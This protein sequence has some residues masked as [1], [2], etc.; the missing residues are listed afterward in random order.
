MATDRESRVAWFA[1]LLVA[2]A[3]MCGP[4]G[5]TSPAM[6]AAA[7]NGAALMARVRAP[8][9]AYATDARVR[10]LSIG[11]SQPRTVLDLRIR[12]KPFGSTLKALIEVTNPPSRAGRLLLVSTVAGVEAHARF[13]GPQPTSSHGDSTSVGEW[14]SPCLA[15]EDL[16]DAHYAW[17]SHAVLREEQFQGRLAAIVQSEPGPGTTSRYRSVRTW[18]DV[19]RLVP[20]RAEK[21]VRAD[22][23][24]TRF[25]YGAIRR[26][27]DLWVPRE[28]DVVS[29]TSACHVQL[30]VLQGTTRARL[31]DALF[32]ETDFGGVRR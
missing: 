24:V 8:V 17:S 1:T 18:I 28:I 7:T 16:V 30:T 5:S 13:P 22:G 6:A 10:L 21:T 25:S 23:S 31:D 11:A 20:L 26:R 2:W 29:P 4:A 32:N 27:D 19:E 15:P 3:L 12:T 9:L 14:L